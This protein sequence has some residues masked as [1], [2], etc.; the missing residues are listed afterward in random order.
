MRRM[1]TSAAR[2]AIVLGLT[3]LA[4][5]ADRSLLAQEA[6]IGLAKG[7]TPSAVALTRLDGEGGVVDLAGVIGAR[8]VLLQFW[9]T[10]CTN[11]EALAPRMEAAVQK[12]GDRVSFYAIAVGV[13]Q[14]PRRIRRHLETHPVPYPVLWDERG[15]AVR[16]FEAPNTSYVV[17]LD[18]EGRVAYTGTGADQD[19]DAALRSAL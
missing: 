5:R 6:R 13:N 14:S 8:P 17:V 11:C 4:G 3:L 16:S 19:I 12:Y 1:R 18:A 15:A 2:S 9:A 7:A 10:W